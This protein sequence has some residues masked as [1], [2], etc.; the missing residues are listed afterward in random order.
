MLFTSPIFMFLFLPI[1]MCVYAVVGKNRRRICLTIIFIAFYL[2]FNIRSP[3]NMLYLPCLIVYSYLSMKLLKIKRNAPL[4]VLLCALPYIALFTVR[5]IAY[6]GSGD[7]LY[8]VGLTVSVLFSTS[9]IITQY[10]QNGTE[11]GTFFDLVRYILFFPVMIAGPIVR[12]ED[13]LRI[14]DEKEIRFD[15]A[16]VASGI[17]LFCIG[18]VKRIAVGA[19][20]YEMYDVFFEL[21]YDTPNILVTVF[22]LV[23]VYFFVFFTIAGY[24]DIGVGL[25]K[26]YGLSLETYVVADPFRAST[27][28]T[29]FGNLFTGL[30]LWI[31]DYLIAPVFS[32]VPENKKRLSSLIRAVC[33]GVVSILFIRS[34]PA[35]IA[36]SVPVVIFFYISFR[37]RLDERLSHRTGLRTLMTL[38]TMVAVATVWVFILLGDPRLIVD[39][40][41]DMTAENSEYR[42]DQILSTFSGMKYLFV[43]IIAGLAMWVSRIEAYMRAPELSKKKVYTWV[44]YISFALILVMFSFTV[45]FFLP[46][47]EIYNYTPFL[48]LFI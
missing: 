20:L 41:E 4:C 34:T 7:F 31:D 3:L 37:Y 30:S 27:F 29:Y 17:R 14:T 43:M 13:F 45:I 22:M 21:F 36:L 40:I 11:A 47:F 44:Q 26:M 35:M 23:T 15:N 1:S 6:F 18:A 38:V 39:Y 33:Y 24:I 9:Y 46:Q 19:V 28:T 2:L 32:R 16:N 8:P 12:Y 48:H 42:M 10:R 25:A 5:G